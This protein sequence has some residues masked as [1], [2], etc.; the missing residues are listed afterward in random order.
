MPLPIDMEEEQRREF[1]LIFHGRL[2]LARQ[3]LRDALDLIEILLE[4]QT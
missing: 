1:S 3:Y 4:R 2:N